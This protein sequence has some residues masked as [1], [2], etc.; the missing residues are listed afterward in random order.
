MANNLCNAVL[1]LGVTRSGR[2]FRPGDW[3]D[4][5]AGWFSTFGKDRLL[6]YSPCVRPV[7]VDGIRGLLVDGS[8]L[9]SDPGAFRFLM[10]FAAGNDLLARCLGG[11]VRD[12]SRPDGVAA[13]RDT[14]SKTSS[15][16]SMP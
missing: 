1:I 2:T 15:M 16:T 6:K 5:L 11:A 13:L 3:V 10:D 4:R 9:K 7:V 8:L 12:V 14:G